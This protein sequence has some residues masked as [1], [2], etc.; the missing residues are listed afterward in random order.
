MSEFN[1]AA[2]SIIVPM[3]NEQASIAATLSA[4]RAG[5]PDAE[6]I[7]VDGGSVDGS[8]GIA[9]ALCDFCSK[10]PADAQIS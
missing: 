4:L 5:A 10:L 3:L 9:G 1:H 7:V 6:V 8:Q 2:L